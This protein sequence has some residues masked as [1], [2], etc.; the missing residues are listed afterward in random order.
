M[1]GYEGDIVNKKRKSERK[2]VFFFFFFFVK[3][4]NTKNDNDFKQIPEKKRTII[5]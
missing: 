3:S 5:D 1:D 2:K 4:A